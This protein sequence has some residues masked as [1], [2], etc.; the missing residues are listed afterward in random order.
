MAHSASTVHGCRV[1]GWLPTAP[2]PA[3]AASL[4]S[5]F[6]LTPQDLCSSP[7]FWLLFMMLFLSWQSLLVATYIWKIVPFAFIHKA[8]STPYIDPG[9]GSISS[10]LEGGLHDWQSVT[11]FRL[12][13][14]GAVAGSL[15]I[16]GRLI[17]GCIGSKAG[18]KRA[19]VSIASAIWY[20]LPHYCHLTSS[21]HASSGIVLNPQRF[22]VSCCRR[23]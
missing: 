9:N 7:S 11:D 6:V 23:L 18:N 10:A 16:A 21:D 1:V 14:V 8:P 2:S 5:S 17:W 4:L 3:T 20:F 15:C 13:I 22:L 12:S 19:L